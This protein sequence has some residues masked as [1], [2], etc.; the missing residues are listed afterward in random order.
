[1]LSH[2][3]DMEVFARKGDFEALVTNLKD[4]GLK[5]KVEGPLAVESGTMSFL[6]RVFR[7]R[8]DGSV[9]VTMNSKYIEGWVEVL[10]LGE[11][12]PKKVPCPSDGGRA[13]KS[14]KGGE[15]LWKE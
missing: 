13:F 12:F 4:E 1:M 14:R 11:A 7:T 3:D 8:G 10:E 6:K 2:V 15:D 9:E 5:I